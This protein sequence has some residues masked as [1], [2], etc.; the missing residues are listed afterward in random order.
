MCSCRA[1]LLFQI[2]ASSTGALMIQSR[3]IKKTGK[4]QRENGYCRIW[5]WW[6]GVDGRRCLTHT[7][8]NQLMCKCRGA[9]VSSQQPGEKWNHNCGC[10][11][12]FLYTFST[13][14]GC[15]YTHHLFSVKQSSCIS[16]PAKMIRFLVLS[17]PNMHWGRGGRR[18]SRR[19]WGRQRESI[20]F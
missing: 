2:I 17:K 11:V 20:I 15:L 10:L 3:V 16:A 6:H 18:K 1:H 5:S 19:C 14:R 12:D 9:G 8:A 7:E 4:G 13:F